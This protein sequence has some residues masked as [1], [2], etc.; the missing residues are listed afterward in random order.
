M[1]IELL[2]H[3]SIKLTGKTTIYFDPYQIKETK[4]D[5]DIIFITHDHYDHC[6]ETSV[7]NIMNEN[8][9]LVVPKT[10]E[11]PAKILT[12]KTYLR[13]KNEYFWK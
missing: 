5:A 10:L 3:A 7:K 13:G 8:T 9:I 11:E 4:N 6:E 2:H 1:N 12:E